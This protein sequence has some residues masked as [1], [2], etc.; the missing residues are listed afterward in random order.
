MRKFLSVLLCAVMVLSMIPVIG[1]TASA[2]D[3]SIGELPPV[4]LP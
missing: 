1:I 3:G 4:I 2:A